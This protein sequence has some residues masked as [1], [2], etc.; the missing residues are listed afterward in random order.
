MNRSGKLNDSLLGACS[1]TTR[2]GGLPAWRIAQSRG[3]LAREVVIAVARLSNTVRAP[4]DNV[5]LKGVTRAE[6]TIGVG[7]RASEDTGGGVAVDTL[8]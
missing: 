8:A 4:D 3:K 1:I 7:G 2:V 5:A 6:R